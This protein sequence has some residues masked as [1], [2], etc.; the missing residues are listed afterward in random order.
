MRKIDD[1]PPPTFLERCDSKRVK[2]WGSA[3]DMIWRDLGNSG[4]EA[5]KRVRGGRGVAVR[6]PAK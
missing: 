1:P 2:G 4:K 5:G 3:N 6:G